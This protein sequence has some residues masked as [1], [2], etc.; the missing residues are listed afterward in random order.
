MKSCKI[1]SDLFKREKGGAY[2]IMAITLQYRDAKGGNYFNE[3]S[4]PKKD[5]T[6]MTFCAKK[7][8]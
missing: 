8:K 3:T 5:V 2:R 4:K 6:S 7:M 1:H